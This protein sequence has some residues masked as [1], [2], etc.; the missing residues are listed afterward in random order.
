[1][2]ARTFDLK[3]AYRQIALCEAGKKF[4]HIA[5]YCPHLQRAQFFKSLVLPFGA[6][7][8]VH[9]FLR[10]ARAIWWIGTKL[11]KLMWT[12][13][14]DDYI[15]LSPPSLSHSAEASAQALLRLLGWVFAEDGRK[16]APFDT[17][18]KAL[19]VCFVFDDSR[20]GRCEIKNT[21]ERVQELAKISCFWLNVAKCQAMRPED[22]MAEWF[23]QTLKFLA[24]RERGVCVF[25]LAAPRG[26]QQCSPVTTSCF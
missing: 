14:Y 21:P 9:S 15:L 6:V 5:V 10:V 2:V 12:S 1:M 19:G 3:S 18:C 7:R 17:N 11:F 24:V 16:A 23:L 26:F 22:F 4:A 13:F 25:Y 20:A 8:S